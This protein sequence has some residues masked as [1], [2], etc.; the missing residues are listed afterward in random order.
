LAS[1]R[2][3]AR[4]EHDPEKWEPFSEEIMLNRKDEIMIRSNR[5]MIWR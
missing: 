1:S 5:I 3:T 4:L 2:S